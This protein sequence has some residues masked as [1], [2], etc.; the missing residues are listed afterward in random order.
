MNPLALITGAEYRLGKSIALELVHQGFAVCLHYHRRNDLIEATAAELREQGG[1]VYTM[2]SDLR[3]PSNIEDLFAKVSNLPN[4]LRVLI[5]SVSYSPRVDL[6]DLSLDEWNATFNLNLRAPWLCIRDAA[7]LMAQEAGA[8]INLSDS[9]AIKGEMEF[10]A[11]AISAVG[12]ERLTRV[13]A[14]VF[15]PNIRVNTVTCGLILPSGNDTTP[16]E[17]GPLLE[18]LPMKSVGKIEDVTSVVMF[19][20]QNTFVTGSVIAADGGYN[21]GSTMFVR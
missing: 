18:R 13:A 14:R 15:A 7:R 9:P 1:Q 12:L 21:L 11:Y 17:W 4:P 3:E 5:N 16:D 19:F 10:P 20:I 2:L 8:I 6:K